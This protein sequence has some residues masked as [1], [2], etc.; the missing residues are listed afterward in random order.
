MEGG[1]RAG[2]GGSVS[3]QAD[4]LWNLS[5]ELSARLRQVDD[6]TLSR[7]FAN[8]RDAVA[9]ASDLVGGGGQ[10]GNSQRTT[11]ADSLYAVVDACDEL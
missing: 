4:A 1:L 3:Q 11:I 9:L 7:L 5:I 10:L 2:A 8:A 6:P